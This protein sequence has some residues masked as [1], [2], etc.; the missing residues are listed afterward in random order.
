MTIAYLLLAINHP[1][2]PIS[3]SLY[4]SK[5]SRFNETNFTIST[6]KPLLNNGQSAGGSVEK[7]LT[8][9]LLKRQWKVSLSVASADTLCALAGGCT[10]GPAGI[11]CNWFLSNHSPH[12]TFNSYTLLLN[13][14]PY[15]F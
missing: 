2:I 3:L 12:P 9:L 6:I 8:H 1:I 4:Q 15:E 14:L 13:I 10:V 5:K 7:S 11:T